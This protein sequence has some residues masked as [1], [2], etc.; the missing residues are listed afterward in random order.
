MIMKA[1]RLHS[2][3]ICTALAFLGSFFFFQFAYPYHLMRREQLDLFLWDGDHIARTY[4]GA[5]WLA[6]LGGDFLEQFFGLPVVGPLIVALLLTAI[7]VVVYRICR[8]FL[9]HWPSL[10]IATVVFL[11]SF[12]RETGNNYMTCYTLVVLGYLSLVLLALQFKR[13]WLQG[14]AVAVFLA[15]GA[16]ALASPYHPQYGRLWGTPKPDDERMF[17]LDI[18]VSREH[19]DKVLKL[20]E[21][22]LYMEEASYCYNLAQA[23]EGNLGNAL[24]NHSQNHQFSLLF[25]VSADRAI[26]TNTL[27]GEA[28][29]QLGDMTMAEQSA[30]T[31]LQASP[32]H[33]GVRFVTRLARVNLITG[34][35]A[36]AQK[37]LNMLGGTL[38]Y[39]KWARR[40]MPGRQDGSLREKLAEDRAKLTGK[41]FVHQA[42]NPRAVLLGLLEADST[43]VTARNYLLCYD[44]LCYD[45]DSFIRDYEPDRIPA[46]LYHE[47]ILIWLSQQGRL[48][49]EEVAGYGVDVSNVDRMG[50]FGKNPTA[51][52]NT[53][54]YYYWRM[55]N[56]Q[57]PE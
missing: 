6:R 23:M 21:K 26:F 51:F 8:H 5:G 43:N 11:W 31:S 20:S 38:F 42:E 18:E 53:Y 27:A 7:G 36:A 44:L 19:W 56:E 35:D 4:R 37:Y 17:G 41:D 52:K 10:V 9:G 45:L 33:T 39:R 22:D 54:W 30:I 34:E 57:L 46:R 24:L 49:P 50:R 12:M 32:R 15:F 48:T 14:V 28:W 1:D 2:G 13:G 40:M 47:A 29:F 55:M 16:W 3:P 25:P